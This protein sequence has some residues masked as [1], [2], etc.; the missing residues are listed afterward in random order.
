MELY[1]QVNSIGKGVGVTGIRG[2]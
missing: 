2:L 1:F